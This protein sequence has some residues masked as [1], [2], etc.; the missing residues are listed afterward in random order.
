MVNMRNKYGKQL[1]QFIDPKNDFFLVKFP[2]PSWNAL[3]FF[4]TAQT[5]RIIIVVY[6]NTI[7]HRLICVC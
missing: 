6:V 5:T 2:I 4:L 1:F 3:I 7:L